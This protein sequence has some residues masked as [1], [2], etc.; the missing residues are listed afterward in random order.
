MVFTQE[1]IYLKKGW[2]IYNKF[3]WVWIN[4][5]SLM[6]NIKNSIRNKS[7]IT[8]IWFNNVGILCIGFIDFMLE[9]KILLEYTD[10]FSPK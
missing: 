2:G 10:L 3:W 8:N 5:N 4:M 9:G 6:L 1:I 7:I